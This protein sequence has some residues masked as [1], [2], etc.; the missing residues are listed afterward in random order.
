MLSNA[1]RCLVRSS[2]SAAVVVQS[3]GPSAR[4]FSFVRRRRRC[5]DDARPFTIVVTGHGSEL[6]GTLDSHENPPNHPQGSSC[7]PPR[8][9]HKFPSITVRDCNFASCR[10]QSDKGFYYTS[11]DPVR[12]EL[13]KYIHTIAMKHAPPSSL[14][15]LVVQFHERQ[16]A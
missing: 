7:P 15:A 3:V 5:D 2:H 13:Q 11:Q 6:Y 8:V 4:R 16:T 1:K 14:C 10:I 9:D 12:S